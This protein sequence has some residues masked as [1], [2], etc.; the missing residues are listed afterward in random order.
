MRP[1]ASKTKVFSVRSKDAG[2]KFNTANKLT[3][4][5]LTYKAAE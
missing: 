2:S 4:E 1:D 5:P 3:T